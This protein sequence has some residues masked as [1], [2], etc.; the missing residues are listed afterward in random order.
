[1]QL[2]GL[3]GQARVGKDTVAAHLYRHYDFEQTSF[4]EPMKQMLEAAFGN[5]FRTG[6][7]EQPMD[8]L[9]KSPRHLMQT[10]GTEWGRNCVH[11]ELWT[12]L[13][14]DTIRV[15][16]ARKWPGLVLTDV[17]FH[18]EADM[19]L[20]NGG[21]LIHVVRDT[22]AKVNDHV[23]EQYTWDDYPMRLTLDNNGTLPLL[24]SRIDRIMANLS[25]AA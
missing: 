10:L 18:N 14:E 16:K 2:I 8:W 20:R 13:A 1:M 25:I 9:G 6:D 22:G 12:L 17:R 7:R 15:A 3:I 21:T 11:P 5:K 19:I 4:A 24:F 23:S